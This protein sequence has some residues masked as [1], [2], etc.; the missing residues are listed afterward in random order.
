MRDVGSFEQGL[1]ILLFAILILRHP[2]QRRVPVW[3]WFIMLAA[4]VC[5]TFM[6]DSR[7]GVAAAIAA[8]VL[9]LAYLESTGRLARVLGIGNGRRV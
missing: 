7:Q 4:W 1:G 2:T 5:L 9:C 8:V 3:V 6:G